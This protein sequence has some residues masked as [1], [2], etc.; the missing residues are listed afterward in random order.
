MYNVVIAD[1]EPL[2]LI[3]M[4]SII[5]W[6]E[7]HARIVATVRNG[8]DL[9][10]K[11]QETKPDI[12]ITDIKMPLLSGL[13]VMEKCMAAKLRLPLF[14][15]LTGY[16]E[17]QLVKKA[18]NLNAVDYLV[19]LELTP[20]MLGSAVD[21]AIA[22]I[23][24][25]HLEGGEVHDDETMLQV[26]RDRIYIRL[27]N[28]LAVDASQLQELGIR[29]EKPYVSVAYL[30]FKGKE[31][32]T[33]KEIATLYYSASQMLGETLSGLT[34]CHLIP[35]DIRHVVILFFLSGNPRQSETILR[36]ALGK[37]STVV[38]NY[39]GIRCLGAVG[40]EVEGLVHCGVSFASARTDAEKATDDH[41]LVYALV[42]ET[43]ESLDLGPYREK[44]SESLTEMDGVA[45][46]ELCQR[47]GRAFIED[48]V[49][50][51]SAISATSGVLFLV[52]TM[53]PDGEEEVRNIFTGNQLDYR[54]IYQA[55][56]VAECF[57]YLSLL[58]EGM[59]HVMAERRQD[60]RSVVVRKVQEYIKT[61]LDK[62]LSL[63][64]V[65][66]VFGFSEN[67]LSSLFSKYGDVGFV[68]YTT[69]VK[70]DKAKEMM[71]QG[72]YKVYEIAE[73]LG[74][75]SA[76]Y[77]SKV[78]KKHEGLSPRDYVQKLYGRKIDDPDA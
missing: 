37:A 16:E 13:E 66:S 74:F 35:L 45:F 57:R 43:K 55:R 32:G 68:E 9:W 19:K 41:P 47:M 42:G 5:P 78:F 26:L 14:I 60:W 20:Q 7:H 54:M 8:R 6:D 2:S 21:K 69:E 28:G 73:A 11:I 29:D 36:G 22:R 76:F 10:E 4:K 40:K 31:E 34:S 24:S 44:L 49:S 25:E 75:E 62:R 65:A 18:I 58:S 39:F 61:N 12:V 27:I 15:L 17:F 59:A 63:S 23:E 72:N 33:A 1:D 71:R 3:G 53:F 48:N 38:R 77:F 50:L 67:Y 51:L 30:T 46:G 52:L 70:M 64:D 56:S